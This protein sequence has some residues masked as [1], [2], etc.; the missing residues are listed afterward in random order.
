MNYEPTQKTYQLCFTESES[1]KFLTSIRSIHRAIVLRP[2]KCQ[3]FLRTPI[4][5][6]ASPIWNCSLMGSKILTIT[7]NALPRHWREANRRNFGGC[8]CSSGWQV[9]F[10]QYRNRLKRGSMNAVALEPLGYTPDK[11]HVLLEEGVC[12]LFKSG[13]VFARS[14]E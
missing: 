1:C 9:A 7:P 2:S 3:Y 4:H 11:D 12:K 14:A 6:Y 8:L 10:H 13:T 5:G